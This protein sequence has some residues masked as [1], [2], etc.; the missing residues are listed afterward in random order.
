MSAL[1]PSFQRR[2]KTDVSGLIR[3]GSGSF[4]DKEVVETLNEEWTRFDAEKRKLLDRKGALE[5]KFATY[6][7][8]VEEARLANRQPAP[9]AHPSESL[10]RPLSKSIPLRRRM[11]DGEGSNQDEPPEVDLLSTSPSSQMASRRSSA[12]SLQMDRSTALGM[13]MAHADLYRTER[14]IAKAKRDNADEFRRM[15]MTPEPAPTK[16]ARMA[17]S[18]RAHGWKL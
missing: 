4:L 8:S 18:A 7:K 1:S 5:R 9:V 14:T 11:R 15:G 13:R 16:P 2:N 6:H 12:P 3:M 17:A 10:M